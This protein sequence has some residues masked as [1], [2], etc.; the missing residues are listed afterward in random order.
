M[1]LSYPLVPTE[2]SWEGDAVAFYQRNSLALAIVTA[3]YYPVIFGIQHVMKNREPFDLGGFG[4]KATINY[5][6]WWELGLGFFSIVG[7]LHVV[8]MAIAP[9]LVSVVG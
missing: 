6:F 8:P 7:A 9:I 4:S 3:L 1:E 5:I 2:W